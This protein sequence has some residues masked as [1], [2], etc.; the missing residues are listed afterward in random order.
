VDTITFPE[1]SMYPLIT[2]ELCIGC[3]ICI[4]RCPF[5]AIK[6]VTLPDEL[7]KEIVHQ[8]GENSFRVYSIPVPSKGIT[9]ILGPNGMGKTTTMNI[10]SGVLIPN[11]GNYN[12]AGDKNMVLEKYSNS[13]LGEYFQEIYEGSKRVVLKSQ[14]V[15]QI[16]KVAKG[17]IGEILKGADTLGMADDII[18]ELTME[19]S[20]DKNVKSASGGELQKLAMAMTLI[21]DGDIMLIDEISSYLDIAERLRVASILTNLAKKGKTIFVVEHDLAILDWISDQIHLI[22]GSSGAYGVIVQQKSPNKAINQFLEGYFK[23]EN[24]RIRKE[25]ISFE[26]RGANRKIVTPELVTWDGIEVTLGNFKLVVEHG[27]L[28]IGTVTGILGGNALGKST[29]VKILSGIQKQDKGVVAPLLKIAYKPQYISTAF[30]GTC[31]DLLFT[32][33]KERMSDNFVKNDLFRSLGIDPLMQSYVVD[34]SGG[35]LQRL[36]IAMTLAQEADL[37]LLDEP[38]A[39]LDSSA[40]MEVAKVIRKTIENRKKTGLVVD[41]DIYFIDII[42][43]ELMVFLGEPG[44]SGR[45]IG[46]MSMREGM[47][48]FLKEANVTFRRDHNS[49]RPRINKPGSSLHREQVSTGEYY[50]S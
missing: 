6:I 12:E 24:V 33:L 43:D 29:F 15:D 42:S 28:A 32:T 2:E 27:K 21:K 34:L 13:V 9:A 5:G 50:Y 37:Y 3:G 36:S 18:A 41:H 20:L 26:T 46:P 4:N 45:G 44:K 49:Q 8:Y 22:Y 19:N 40:R 35:E 30:D 39:N 16:P 23:E 10:L 38:S 1:G 31:E 14:Y 7:N 17:T 47:N 25:K 48:I 11:F